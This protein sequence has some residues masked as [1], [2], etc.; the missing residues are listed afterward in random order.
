MTS[1]S[2]PK[3]TITKRLH[4]SPEFWAQARRDYLAA[5]AVS[6]RYWMSV[7]AIL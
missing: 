7:D 5:S 2:K 3:R 6:K 4:H 1:E